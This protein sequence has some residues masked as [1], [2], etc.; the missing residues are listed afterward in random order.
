MREFKFFVGYIDS[1]FMEIDWDLI[2]RLNDFNRITTYP[3]WT[4]TTYTPTWIVNPGLIQYTPPNYT[5]TTTPGTG[6][7]TIPYNGTVN[8][9]NS[10]SLTSSNGNGITHTNLGISTN[11]SNTFLSTTGT[12]TGFSSSSFK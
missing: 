6:T 5:I 4:G 1:P 3:T 2:N 10:F 9:A 12:L 7:Y 8:T 11:T